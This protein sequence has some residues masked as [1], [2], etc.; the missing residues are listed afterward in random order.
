MY[1]LPAVVGSVGIVMVTGIYY[2]TYFY[3]DICR[4]GAGLLCKPRFPNSA[5]RLASPVLGPVRIFELAFGFGMILGP[6]SLVPIGSR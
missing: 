3:S 5:L 4:P 6:T 2:R 1:G